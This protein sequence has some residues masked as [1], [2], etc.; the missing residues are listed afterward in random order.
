[1]SSPGAGRPVIIPIFHRDLREIMV[2]LV[3]W[4]ARVYTTDESD[5]TWVHPQRPSTSPRHSVDL[6]IKRHDMLQCCFICRYL[7]VPAHTI[8]NPILTGALADRLLLSCTENATRRSSRRRRGLIAICLAQRG[9]AT[10]R[11]W[12]HP[13]CRSHATHPLSRRTSKIRGE[14]NEGHTNDTNR[15]IRD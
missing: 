3:I 15:N 7:R 1:M 11:Q 4:A 6:C 2:V 14:R 12:D 13:I 9:Y 10:G 8:P 5:R